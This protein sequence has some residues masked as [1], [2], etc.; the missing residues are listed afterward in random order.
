MGHNETD[1]TKEIGPG[2]YN[3]AM[4]DTKRTFSIRNDE[5]GRFADI[6]GIR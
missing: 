1:P 3:P 4:N 6:K 2:K 5:K